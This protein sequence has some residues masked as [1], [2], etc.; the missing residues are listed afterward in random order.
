MPIKIECDECGK[1]YRLPDDRAGEW[2]ECRECGADIEVPDDGDAAR[3]E[4]PRRRGS[5]SSS[6]RGRRK[7]ATNRNEGLSAGAKRA[8][9]GGV[10][11]LTMIA[12]LVIA[13]S[14]GGN[15]PAPVAPNPN[16]D[17]IADRDRRSPSLRPGVEPATQ[18]DRSNVSNTNP[19]PG[20]RP[21]L[22]PEMRPAPEAVATPG[23]PRASDA[24]N[25]RVTVDPALKP[26]VDPDAE[27]V[28]KIDNSKPI[29]ITFPKDSRG[30]S[31]MLM[32]S[33]PI[34]T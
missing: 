13:L 23:P 27:P 28:A 33:R 32:P 20:V 7:A 19:Q 4:K 29:S 10:F 26:E 5:G 34:G 14:G 21:G 6:G 2:I 17:R 1:K 3:D 22:P 31:A 8:I 9:F 30:S 25:W 16:G 15:E 11:A 24:I 18:P 12:A